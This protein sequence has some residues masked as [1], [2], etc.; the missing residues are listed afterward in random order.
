MALPLEAISGDVHGIRVA[1]VL[2]QLESANKE[3]GQREPVSNL[4]LIA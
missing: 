1:G 4:S 2:G 3:G